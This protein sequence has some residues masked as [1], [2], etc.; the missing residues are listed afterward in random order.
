MTQIHQL[1]NARSELWLPR[2]SLGGCIRGVMVRDTRGVMLGPEQRFSHY[3]ATPL[4]SISWYLDG[5]V[6]MLL[7][8]CSPTLDAPRQVMAARV[9]FS[10]PQQQ[11]TTTW[12][13]GEG[14]GLMLLLLPDAFE[15][16]TGLAPGQWLNC[17]VDAQD[18]LPQP[19]LVLSE[20]IQNATDDAS[21]VHLIEEF[22]EPRWQACRP[23]HA[24]GVRRYADWTQ[25]LALRAATS[26]VGRS[27]RQ[28]ERRILQWAG[29]PIRELRGF[30]RAERAFFDFMV[31]AE[32]MPMD[33]VGV[34][35]D[36]GFSD[37]SHLCRTSRR[38][39]GYSPTALRDRIARDEG[40]WPYRIWQ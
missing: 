29:Q 25:G 33:W 3:P 12:S 30:G 27:L 39:T 21:R 36:N 7:P 38:M 32:T 31:R 24:R 4:C 20:Q 16:L 37:Q 6:D 18:V 40:F 35:L 11:P 1:S 10:G 15:L 22:L 9:V 13:R 28:V 34:A 19:W 14:Y 17:T 8:G 23:S 26:Q 5:E 2:L